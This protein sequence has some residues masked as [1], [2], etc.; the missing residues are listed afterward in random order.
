MT[1]RGKFS[2]DLESVPVPNPK[3]TIMGV[4]IQPYCECNDS[5]NIFSNGGIIMKFTK[6]CDAPFYCDHCGIIS[7]GNIM[8]EKHTCSKCEKTLTMYGKLLDKS[9]PENSEKVVVDWAVAADIE[10]ILEDKYYYCPRCKKETLR[11]Q[12]CG[13]WF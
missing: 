4:I 2:Q 13:N 6:N 10:Y 11:F 5:Y 1:R 12:P 3:K 9:S 8:E 7:H